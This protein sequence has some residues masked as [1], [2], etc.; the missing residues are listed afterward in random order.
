MNIKTLCITGALLL[1]GISIYAQ[2]K[3]EVINDSNTPLHLLQPA[4]KVPYKALTTS[5]VKTDIDRVL[6]YLEKTTPTRVVSE[7]TGKVI[8]DYNN[9]PADAQLERGAFRLASYEWGVTYS[10]MLAA[11]E[12]TG[13]ADYKKY[14]TDRFNFLAEVAPRFREMLEKNGTT[15]PQMKQILTPHALDDAGAVCAAMIKAQLQDKS[16][17]L[18][19]LIENYL[20]FILNKEYRLADGTFARTRPQLNTLWLDDMFMGIPPVAWY[21]QLAKENQQKYLA[22]AVRQIFQ[23]AERM[24]VPEKKLFRHGWVE[25]MQDHPAFH[26]G[27]ANGWALLTMTE[28]LDVMPENHPQRAK[29]MELF[30]GH[31][32][33]LAACQSGEGFWHQL[34]DRNDSYLETSATAIYVYC[35]AHGINKGWLDALAYGPVAQLGWHAVS[36][37]IN[38]E[39]QVEGT[40]VGTGMAFDPAFYYYRPV[41]VYAAHGYGP[42]IWAGAEMINLLNK[43]HPKMND[44]AI[45]YY[46][47][48]QKTTAPIFSV[49]ESK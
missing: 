12:A 14:V 7:K 37:Q 34:L 41:N 17:N 39:G 43:Q 20:D 22:E 15:D 44:S 21:S 23:F 40:C 30:R 11:A 13:D 38:A 16:L 4:Y 48:E 26:W 32:R 2:K 35:M 19:P 47:T 27:R 3:K 25:S 1:S 45:Q 46:S 31:V 9:L 6:R 5:E 29:L 10:A 8:T 49:T 24:W 36:T 42:V 28:V 18:Y 33:G